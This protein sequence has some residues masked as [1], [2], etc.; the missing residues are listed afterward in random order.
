MYG[1]TGY[2]QVPYGAATSGAHFDRTTGDSWTIAD[3]VLLG[4]VGYESWDVADQAHV[5]AQGVLRA[6][7]SWTVDDSLAGLTGKTVYDS[8]GVADAVT[9]TTHVSVSASDSWTMAD[10]VVAYVV[11]MVDLPATLALEAQPHALV[12]SAAGRLTLEGAGTLQLK[13]DANTQTLKPEP[14]GLTLKDE[15]EELS[16]DG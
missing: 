1:G 8:F 16:T 10:A 7:D 2:G 15:T 5:S 9:R 3:S 6:S 14:R 13:S 11:R 4:P 12:L